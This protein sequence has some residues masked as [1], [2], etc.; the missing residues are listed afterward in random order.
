MGFHVFGNVKSGGFSKAK[1]SDCNH[2]E[3]GYKARGEIDFESDKSFCQ[4][5]PQ[6]QELPAHRYNKSK[7]KRQQ[8]RV[9][10]L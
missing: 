7:K 9:E 8:K 2:F 6:A 1:M 4:E 10:T 5:R 3:L